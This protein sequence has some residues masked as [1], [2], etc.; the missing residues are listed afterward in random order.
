MGLPASVAGEV[1]LV[2]AIDKLAQHVE[3]VADFEDCSAAKGGD[4]HDFGAESEPGAAF[5]VVLDVLGTVPADFEVPG[6]SVVQ[7]AAWN[8]LVDEVEVAGK[9][10]GQLVECVVG[11]EVVAVLQ[12]EIVVD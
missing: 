4:G 8:E 1:E 11:F 5:E 6:N 10:V 7:E 3:L 2:D 12:N 9:A